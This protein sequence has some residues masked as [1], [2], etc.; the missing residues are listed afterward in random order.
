MAATTNLH[1][2]IVAATYTV[3]D[4]VSLFKFEIEFR[5]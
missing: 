3:F 2:K 1:G 4:T 5:M